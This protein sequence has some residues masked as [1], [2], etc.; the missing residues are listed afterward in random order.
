MNSEFTL[1]ITYVNSLVNALENST[2]NKFGSA[3]DDF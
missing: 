3:G 1:V 2:R